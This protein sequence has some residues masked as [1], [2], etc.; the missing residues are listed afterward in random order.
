MKTTPI[1]FVIILITSCTQP[2][3]EISSFADYER[4]LRPAQSVS[5][6][7]KE[8]EFRFWTERLSTNHNDATALLKIAGLFA[9]RF[10][11]T[12]QI[13]DIVMS[14]SLYTAVLR[15]TPEDNVSIYHCLA[16]N[17]VAQH[18]FRLAGTYAKK[19]LEQNDK[20]AASL[21]IMT[22]VAL[23]LGDYAKARRTLNQFSNK[24]AFAY[25]IREA[26][27]KDHE[28]KLDTAILLMEKA[29]DRIKGNKALAQWTLSNLAD[30]Y[31]HAGEIDKGY[32]AYLNV[33][34]NNPQDDYALRGIAWI[35]ISND[36]NTVDSKAIINTLVARKRMPEA[37]L[38]LAEIAE[39]E[40]NETEK[41][42]NL[43]KF[44]A[45]A[46]LP[47]YKTM[48]HKYLAI[49]YAE[50]FQDP[51]ACLKIASEE[52][53]NRPT[54][55]SYDLLAWGYY[56]QKNF[57]K[58]LEVA[59]NSVEHQTFEPEAY[60]HLGMIYLAAGNRARARFYLE[61]A[62]ASEFELGPSI[63]EKIKKTINT[64]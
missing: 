20:K 10:K 60:Y 7:P 61:E 47:S 9:E 3:K 13:Q 4:Y 2:Q 46:S 45:M 58:A 8:E 55:Q 64:L 41:I 37:Y 44:M 63:G 27:L 42:K 24:N 62:L 15:F 40:G 35:A 39:V 5:N 32:E 48:Y 33:L 59:T 56:H 19:A 11:L 38:L 21:L 31:G 34:T 57:K 17:A 6:D 16:A 1:L 30:M 12:G 26:K 28:G 49:L 18:K 29:F 22:D 53:M 54:P 51:E 43:K 52:I 50:E 25:L 14:D 36:R 23:E